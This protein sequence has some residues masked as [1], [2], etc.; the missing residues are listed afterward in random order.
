M[1]CRLKI[2]LKPSVKFV[3]KLLDSYIKILYGLRHS[4]KQDFKSHCRHFSAN[5]QF[6]LYAI[7]YLFAAHLFSLNL[8]V[9]AREN[10]CIKIKALLFNIFFMRSS[11][12]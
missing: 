12:L 8:R 5:L 9:C 7:N 3:K 6:R 2:N 1:P 10:R 4:K 11:F